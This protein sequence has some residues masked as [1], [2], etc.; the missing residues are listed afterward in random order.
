LIVQTLDFLH[1]ILVAVILDRA[2]QVNHLAPVIDAEPDEV[3]RCP[4]NLHDLW[5]VRVQLA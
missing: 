2:M 1:Q 5:D 4:V 3:I